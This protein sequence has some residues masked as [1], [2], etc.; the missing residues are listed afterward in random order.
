[1]P[2]AEKGVARF[3]FDDLCRKPLGAS[4]FLKIA[5]SFHTV[6]IDHIPVLKDGERNAARRFISLI[7]SL[8]DNRVKLAA[9]AATEPVGIYTATDGPEAVSF[10]RA[11]SRLIEMRSEEYLALPHGSIG[12]TGQNPPKS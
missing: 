11:A 1:V 12:E 6:M 7:D 5:R 2:Q 3:D 9:S 8:Y 4:D 10:Q